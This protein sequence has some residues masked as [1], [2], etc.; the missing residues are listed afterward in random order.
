MTPA[1]ARLA[2]PAATEA[3]GRALAGL[4]RPG[5]I[6]ALVGDLGAGKTT[7]ARGLLGGLGLA[8]EA[9]SPSFPI[10][11]AYDPP[12]TR[13]PVWHVDLYRIEDAEDA[14][15]LGLD[16]ALADGALVIEWPERLG[17]RLWPET[18]QLSLSAEPDGARRLTADVPAS[19]EARWSQLRIAG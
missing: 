10:V 18:L 16:D 13:F 11:I 7:L 14:E 15:E 3:I 4:L 1:G 12:E 5:D 6:V 2:D 9:A 17:G 8:G 19:W